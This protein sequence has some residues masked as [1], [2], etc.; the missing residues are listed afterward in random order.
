MP[1][2]DNSGSTQKEERKDPPKKLYS[3]MGF[4]LNPQSRN[5]KFKNSI[6]V[7]NVKGYMDGLM[8]Y[9]KEIASMYLETD[10][11]N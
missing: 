7:K 6:T 9:Y 3:D 8:T 11:N 2:D 4:L 1:L 5:D 10:K